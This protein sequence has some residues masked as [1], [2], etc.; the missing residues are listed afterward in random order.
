MKKPTFMVLVL[1]VIITAIISI[2]LI[3]HASSN[4]TKSLSNRKETNITD[5]I[6]YKTDYVGDDSA[7]FKIITNLP[8]GTF[9][10]GM[11][12]QTDSKPY[13]IEIDYGI[14]DGSNI[15]EQQFNEYWTTEDTQKIFLNN[16]TALFVLVNN[17]DKI[18]LKLEKDQGKIFTVTRKDLEAYYGKDLR[19]YASDT[20]QW[21]KEVLTDTLN[22]KERLQDFFKLHAITEPKTKVE[23]IN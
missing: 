10:H 3:L 6:K 8:G 19:K 22:S 12:L 14:S 17:L 23:I 21:D 20:A 4:N 16:A 1:A 13:G 5:V 15:N 18:T 2:V 9:D 11:T 7:V